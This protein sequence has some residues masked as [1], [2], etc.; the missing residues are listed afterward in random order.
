VE[1]PDF[2]IPRFVVPG[3]I[4][5]AGQSGALAR[6]LPAAELVRTLATETDDVFAQLV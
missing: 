2:P 5:L 1:P 6:A 4:H 3:P